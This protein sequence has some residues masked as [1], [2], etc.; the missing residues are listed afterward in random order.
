MSKNQGALAPEETSPEQVRR[1]FD[2]QKA[3]FLKNP[4]PSLQERRA[5]LDSLFRLVKE[6]E[7]NFV[8]S[9]NHDFGCR[10]PQETRIMEV[11]VAL[12]DI[13][14]IKS[15]LAGWMRTPRKLTSIWF[16]PATARVIR[17][18]LGVVGIIV[19]WNFPMMLAATPLSA[20]LAAGNRVILKMSEHTPA[21]SALFARLVRE[22]YSEDQVAVVLGG[23][24]TAR[25]MTRAPFDRILY[26][27]ATARGVDVLH[28]AAD[29]LTPVTLELGG[30]NPAI[31]HPDFPLETAAARVITAKLLNAGQSCVSVD[32]VMVQ[33]GMEER[34]IQ[35]ASA[36]ASKNYPSM[37]D[38]PD[39]T[40]IIDER[41]YARIIRELEDAREKGATIVEANPYGE[42]F[43]PSS[44]KIPPTFVYN[45]TDDMDLAKEEIFGPVTLVIPYDSIEDAM[46][47]VN[48]RPRPLALY[49][50]DND[51]HR[52]EQ[53]LR[54]TVTGTAAV[55]DAVWQF[56]T[57][58]VPFGGVGHSG[59]GRYHGEYGFAEFSHEK[60]VFIQSRFNQLWTVMPPYDWIT[61][62]VTRLMIR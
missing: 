9:I 7:E 29:N 19:P 6:N 17:Q 10:S 57:F 44:R 47:Y 8:D 5:A 46:A 37:V 42:V 27:G 24:E 53:V 30:K 51:K 40:A 23:P 48:S 45:V 58:G 49:Y 25:A 52:T 16:W 61:R 56:V 21:T 2:L 13:R 11:G 18:P 33:A 35:A 1:L 50:F 55:N 4:Y 20:A 3:A 15:H 59:M 36:H 34:F 12:E 31:I 38:N 14:H 43:D 54:G 41:H 60:G 62:L 28:A 26:T 22:V 32:Y 39:Y